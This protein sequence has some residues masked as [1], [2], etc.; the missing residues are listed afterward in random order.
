MFSLRVSLK[1]DC[2]GSKVDVDVP[3]IAGED[4][5]SLLLLK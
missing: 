5:Q 4:D 1:A 2:S 3:E